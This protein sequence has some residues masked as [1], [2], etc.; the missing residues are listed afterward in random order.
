MK[1]IERFTADF[2]SIMKLPDDNLNDLRKES[3]E[4]FR[5]K[6]LPTRKEEY[7]KYS[8]PSIISKIELKLGT[9][10]EYEDEDYDI[11][12][13][14]GNI[15]KELKECKMGNIPDGIKEGEISESIL[16]KKEKPFLNL[17]NAFTTSGLYLILDENSKQ[18][19]KILNL[20]NNKKSLQAVHPRMEIIANSNSDSLILE[21]FRIVGN[22]T[23]FINSVTEFILKDGA[24]IEHIIVDDFAEET[25]H[26]ANV[27]AKQSKDSNF[28]SHNFSVGKKFARR[29]FNIE[30]DESGANCNLFG[31]Y[32][33]DKE[34]HIDHH[35]TIEHKD[36]HCNSNENYKG[37]LSGK[38]TGV[39][40]GRIHVH[41]DAQKT[42]AIQNNKN[43]LLSDDSIIH[44]KPE[45]EIYADDVKCTHGATVGQLDEKALF[46]LRT[47]GL[48]REKSQRLLMRAYVGEIVDEI[49]NERIRNELMEMILARLPEGN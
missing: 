47:R 28:T 16:E 34:N 7:W 32:F 6:G 39:F 25:Y 11:I 23:N 5:K 3:F 49:S 13:V 36:S 43:L 42:D 45:L 4:E 18:T 19:I 9:S 35:T 17:N 29:D 44:T 15:V 31:L 10:S 24:N 41:P 30:L 27:C 46:Y 38:S 8:D 40:N 48:S 21:E 20:V 2:D 26:I 1:A 14:N 12:L 33:V 22:G 37:I